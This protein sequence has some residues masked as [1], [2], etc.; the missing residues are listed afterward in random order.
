MIIIILSLLFW[1]WALRRLGAPNIYAYAMIGVVMLV[2]VIMHLALPL[3]HPVREATGGSLRPWAVIVVLGAV[4]VGYT[5]LL[6]RIRDSHDQEDEPQHDGPFSQVELERYARHI[7]LRE[8]GGTG[9]QRLKRARVLVVAA[10]GLGSPVLQYLAAA[11]VG[12]LGFIDDDEVTLSNLQRQVLF[13]ENDLDRPKVLAAERRLEALNPHVALRPYNRRLIDDIAVNLFE[14]F[15][16]ILDGSD[17]FETRALVNRTCVQLG[18]PLIS[19]AISQWDGHVTVVHPGKTACM[20]CLF[21]KEPEQGTAPSCA[22]GGVLGA[23]PGVIGSLMA[24]EAI[25]LLTKTGDGLSGRMMIYDA[26]HAETRTIKTER[27]SACVVC[28]AIPVK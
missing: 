8:I 18:L 11:G 3:G 6:R 20:N 27:V 10:G 24:V 22:E 14:D 15:D 16:L 23:L 25:K 26:L 21:P 13:T 17:S 1:I 4:F 28:G 12:T 2:I 19:G 7:V 9:Q 5:A